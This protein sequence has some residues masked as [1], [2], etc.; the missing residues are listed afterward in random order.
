MR[1]TWI[2]AAG[3]ALALA[4]A[5]VGTYYF[6]ARRAG[7][8]LPAVGSQAYE[9]TTSSFYRG[10]AQLQVGLLDDAK[11]E[12]SKAAAL[13]PGEP[14]A[15]ANLG[16][17]H[18]RLGEFDA[19]SEPVA[20]AVALL[21]GSSEL[22]LLQG[23]LEPPA[24][25]SSQASPTCAAPSPPDVRDL[26][27]MARADQNATL[28][29]IAGPS[30]KA[31]VA[32]SVI[33]ISGCQDSQVSM[34]GAAN[35][36]FTEKVKAAWNSGSFSGDY[37]AFWADIVSRM[38]ASQKPNYATTGAPNPDF[39]AQRPFTIVDGAPAS[40][41]GRPTL[42]LGSKGPDVSRLQQ[43]LAD[44]GYS[45][46]VDGDFGP[47]TQGA[48]EQFQA[49]NGLDVDGVVGPATWAALDSAVAPGP[50]PEIGP[51]PTPTP[52][53]RP[54]IRQGATGPDVE[55]LQERLVAW[56]YNIGVDG[57]FGPMTASAVRS[58]QSSNGLTVDGVVG[59]A[60]WEA[61]G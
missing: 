20:R 50:E 51:G 23:R 38:P 31:N 40:T 41:P 6:L 24:A 12:F 47:G 18:L 55:Y 57:N 39:E 28:Q 9:Q 42:R 53:T 60:T 19:A 43:K 49:D 10:L 5:G 29:W 35:G 11:R 1:A 4:A 48:V 32:A 14:A 46:L 37:R 34:D 7:G 8:G 2:A 27:N 44:A 54:T 33:L 45:L 17:A 16:L 21:P 61:L 56:D 58:F 15:W 25:S 59:P 36:L 30:E 26:V 3:L 22:S 52:S 13:A